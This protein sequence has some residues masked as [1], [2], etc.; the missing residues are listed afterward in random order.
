MTLDPV[1]LARDLI[2]IDS[3]TGAEGDVGAWL[4]RLLRDQGYQV[5]EHPVSDGRF[6]VFAHLDA[7]HRGPRQL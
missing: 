7:P 4:A 5:V 3:T 6:N 1:S 2:D